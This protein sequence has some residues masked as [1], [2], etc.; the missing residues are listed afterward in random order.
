MICEFVKNPAGVLSG[1]SVVAAGGLWCS[2]F[3]LLYHQSIA[4]PVTSTADTGIIVACNIVLRCFEG[5]ESER[6]GTQLLVEDTMEDV[7][8]VATTILEEAP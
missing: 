8:H 2:T 1:L 3:L 6:G 5:V 7:V 4:I